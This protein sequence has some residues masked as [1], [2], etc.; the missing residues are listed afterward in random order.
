MSTRLGKFLNEQ[1][2]NKEGD[3]DFGN[4][5]YLSQVDKD[6]SFS[7]LSSPP[8]ERLKFKG[9]DLIF[10]KKE[11]YFVLAIP[12]RENH[13]T[14][15]NK[16]ETQERGLPIAAMYVQ[17]QQPIAWIRTGKNI[18]TVK[19][20]E[21]RQGYRNEGLGKLLYQLVCKHKFIIMCDDELYEGARQVWTALSNDPDFKVSLVDFGEKRIIEDNYKVTSPDD[22][23]VWAIK[24]LE[25]RSKIGRLRKL[26]LTLIDK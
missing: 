20:V 21:V 2:W 18:F 13:P 10:T 26:M 16:T 14:K 9:Q 3:Y 25:P 4:L 19:A 24:E 17:G 22:K 15:N 7:L 8:I 5:G 23:N 11:S 1:A 12:V 6:L